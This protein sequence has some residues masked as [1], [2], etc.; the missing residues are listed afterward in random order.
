MSRLELTTPCGLRQV[1]GV[2]GDQQ[3]AAKVFQVLCP[4]LQ[5][6]SVL[7]KPLI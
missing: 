7:K 2:L 6:P 5:W 1:S 4:V 3:G